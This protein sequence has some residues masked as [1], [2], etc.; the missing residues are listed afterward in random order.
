[1][2]MQKNEKN[3]T[4][5]KSKIKNKQKNTIEGLYKELIK[6]EFCKVANDTS[7]HNL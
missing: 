5:R 7:I 1:M 6:G 4:K 2:Y 3:K